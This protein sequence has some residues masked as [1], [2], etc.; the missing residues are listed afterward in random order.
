[1]C[2]SR[3][4]IQ[5]EYTLHWTFCGRT[6]RLRVT[7]Q[8]SHVLFV[9]TRRPSSRP[10]GGWDP[11]RGPIGFQPTCMLYRLDPSPSCQTTTSSSSEVGYL[12]CE[13]SVFNAL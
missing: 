6:S 12:R 10:F 2:T 9:C 4:W 1:M 7:A 13:R 11:R 3:W 5:N 8:V